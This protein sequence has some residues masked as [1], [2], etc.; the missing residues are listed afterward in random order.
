MKKGIGLLILGSLVLVAGVTMADVTNTGIVEQTVDATNNIGVSLRKAAIGNSEEVKVS[1]TYVQYGTEGTR[2]FVRFATAVSGPVKSIKY[3]RTIEGLGTKEK[4]VNCVYK[5]ISSVGSVYYYD[6]TNVVTTQSE[7]TDKYYWACYTIEFTSD[8]YKASD[9]TAYITVESE[10][11]EDEV[12]TSTPKT[13]S[14]EDLKQQAD[15][16]VYLYTQ[17]DLKTFTEEVAK[18]N[19]AGKTIV[20]AADLTVETK[21]IIAEVNEVVLDLNGHTLNAVYSTGSTTNHIYAIDNY[22]VLTIKGQGEINSRGI[23][24]YGEMTLEGSTI[25]SIDGNGGY[26]VRSL[27]GATFTMNSGKI[28]TTLEDDHMVSE[29]GYDAT[30]VGIDAG[31]TFVMNGGTIDNICDYTFAIDTKGTVVINDG[32]IKSVHSTVSSY[33]KL[34]INGGTFICD[35]LEGITAHALVAWGGSTT[36]VYGG[37]FDGKDNYN[38]F[39]IDAVAG[40]VVNVYGGEFLAVHSGSLYGEGTINVMGGTFFDNPSTRVVA[41]YEAKQNEEGKWVVSEKA[42]V[43]TS[44]SELKELL[45]TEKNIMVEGMITLEGDLAASNVRFYST[46]ANSGIDFNSYNISG[47]GSIEYQN[48][49]LK[50]KTKSVSSS[51]IPAHSFYGGIDY[52]GHSEASYVDCTI[53]GVFTTYSKTINA[54]GCTFKSYVEEGEEYYNVFAYTGGVFNFDDCTFL[55]RDRGLKVYN[56]GKQ[57]YELNLTNCAFVATEDYKVNKALINVDDTYIESCVINLE[58]VTIDEKLSTAKVCS[59]SSAS[60]VTVNQK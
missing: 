43:A 54:R 34:T 23:F 49:Y 56:E 33:G 19:Y 42:V 4:E 38:G 59:Y 7:E 16:T 26:A 47:T 1:R 29:G 35:G 20:L 39:N 41:G 30:T 12:I 3:T 46:K 21:I 58:N 6:G 50:T 40:A 15:S 13:E 44:Y 57:T 55:Y 52:L 28:A 18:P 5:G 37:T 2:Q 10:K 25:T 17:E 31:A 51:D 27:S 36:D 45:K 32:L 53:E 60:K 14:F 11:V 22:G 9:I 48:L 24:N 8:T